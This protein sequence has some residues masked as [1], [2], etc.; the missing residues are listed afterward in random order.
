MFFSLH[1]KGLFCVYLILEITD[2]HCCRA[3]TFRV[4]YFCFVYRIYPWAF[5]YFKYMCSFQLWLLI[6]MSFY[7][8]LSAK[9][10]ATWRYNPAL[11]S[12]AKTDAVRAIAVPLL[13]RWCWGRG[14][15]YLPSTLRRCLRKGLP[16]VLSL[17]RKTTW[18]PSG[19]YWDAN[20]AQW[21]TF[22]FTDLLTR[23][24]AL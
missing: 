15:T 22:W 5:V 14:R 4:K 20:F 19:S 10:D 16:L 7:C 12:E 2:V 18:N 13:L 3:S 21:W 23:K 24:N 1:P 17:S 11:C 9:E 6:F 8:I